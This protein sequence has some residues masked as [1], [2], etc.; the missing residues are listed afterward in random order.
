M[1]C[2]EINYSTFPAPPRQT[3]WDILPS[4]NSWATVHWPSS[5]LVVV[6]AAECKG[7]EDHNA[8]KRQGKKCLERE[9]LSPL[10]GQ[11]QITISERERQRARKREKLGFILPVIFSLTLA[12]SPISNIK[13][14]K[15]SDCSVLWCSGKTELLST[16]FP[17]PSLDNIL[18]YCQSLNFR[19]G[20]CATLSK[21]LYLSVLCHIGHGIPTSKDALEGKWNDVDSTYH[22][23]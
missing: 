16:S 23:I 4:Q 2:M 5:S 18:N 17:I 12:W 21:F 15:L 3:E 6:L 14:C 20:W 10:E 9:L 1:I 8:L 22:V 11:G 7:D 19:L 13:C